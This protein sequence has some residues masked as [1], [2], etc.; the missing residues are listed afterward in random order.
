M[1]MFSDID[2]ADLDRFT[3]GFPTGCSTCCGARLLSGFI[4]RPLT[5]LAAKG[6]G[7]SAAMRT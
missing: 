6:S 1:S 7:S 5:H 2:L 4:H 3:D